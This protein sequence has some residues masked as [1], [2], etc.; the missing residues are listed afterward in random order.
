M[1]RPLRS[2]LYRAARL[3]GDVQAAQKG[4]VSYGKR[5]ARKSAYRRGGGSLSKVLRRMGL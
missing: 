3:L 4:P 1:T 2:S 5:L